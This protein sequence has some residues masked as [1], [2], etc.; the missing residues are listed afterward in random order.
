LEQKFQNPHSIKSIQDFTILVDGQRQYVQITPWQDEFG[1]DW[2]VVVVVPESDFMGEINANTRTT[3]LLCLAALG[4]AT[5]LGIYTSRWI[6][7]P[8][9]QLQKGSELITAGQLNQTVKIKG[10]NELEALAKSFNKMAGQLKES[11]TQLERSNEVLEQRVEER[12]EELVQAKKQAESAN[13]A[14]SEF[15]S[16]M[17]HEL[18]TPLNGIL[19]YV[20]ILKRDRDLNT[21]QKDGLNIIQKSGNHLLTLINDILDLSK[22]EARK[23][24]LYPSDIHL[25]I[26][27]DSVAGIM[28]MRALEQDILFKLEAD[29]HL[30]VGIHADEK[31]LRQVLLNL[32]GNAV[33]FTDQGQVRLRVSQ[34]KS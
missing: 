12:T 8:I 24:E 17:S 14:K 31:R 29:S 20:Q 5:I 9:L 26:F 28:K 2:L 10:I 21:G 7:K 1:L 22:I 3:I 4:L 23:M 32:L 13:Q 15:L 18:R 33:K 34:V 11:F 25:G 6:T 30:P 27:L 16:N 19:G